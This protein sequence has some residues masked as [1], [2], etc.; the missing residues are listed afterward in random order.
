MGAEQHAEGPHDGVDLE[1]DRLGGLEGEGLGDHLAE[2]HVH[3]GDGAQVD[4]EADG[5]RRRLRQAPVLER[6]VEPASDGGF[7]IHAE[8][9][10]GQGEAAAAAADEGELGG[11]EHAVD[12][13]Q[14]E[15]HDD[16][17]EDG[18]DHCAVSGSSKLARATVVPSTA[19]TRTTTTSWGPS[20][21]SSPTSGKRP[22]LCLV[23]GG[24]DRAREELRRVLRDRYEAGVVEIAD[25]DLAVQ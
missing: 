22:S 25:P 3:V 12:D 18:L 20:G 24:V 17:D 9:D 2:D 16:W 19:S 15:D 1:P 14:H 7:A 21:T 8:P 10:A 13:H 4:D 6:P 5:V 11:H 23:P